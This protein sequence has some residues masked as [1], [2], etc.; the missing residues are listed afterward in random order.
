MDLFFIT[1]T[2]ACLTALP[3]VMFL[4]CILQSRD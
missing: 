4:F 2:V 3:V 1:L